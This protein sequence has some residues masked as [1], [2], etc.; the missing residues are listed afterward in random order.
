MTDAA[1]GELDA[2]FEWLE[3]AFA[4]RDGE[5]FFVPIV[6]VFD[7]LRADSGF[8]RLCPVFVALHEECHATMWPKAERP[9][10]Q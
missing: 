10:A 7:P 1:L 9:A 4:E 3:H 6:L 8:G 2:A 5:L